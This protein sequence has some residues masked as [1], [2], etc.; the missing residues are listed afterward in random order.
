MHRFRKG[1]DYQPPS[2][3]HAIPRLRLFQKIDDAISQNCR[4]I[5]ISGPAGSG[6]STL[7]STYLKNRTL[8][9]LWCTLS[10]HDEEISEFFNTFSLTA[11][12]NGLKSKLP[13]FGSEY[14]RNPIT[15]AEILLKDV[16][17]RLPDK[18]VWVFDDFQHLSQSKH[19]A[20]LTS[21]LT[22][23]LPEKVVLVVLSRSL[24]SPELSEKRIDGSLCEITWDDLRIDHAELVELARKLGK[25]DS[26]LDEGKKDRLLSATEG[27]ATGIVLSLMGSGAISSV[28]VL[29]EASI[30]HSDDRRKMYEYFTE[31]VLSTIETEQRRFLYASSLLPSM[32]VADCSR[33]TGNADARKILV[34][35]ENM[36]VFVKRHGNLFH[37]FTYHP[38]FREFLLD[39]LGDIFDASK[40]SELERRAVKILFDNGNT[41]S[42]VDILIQHQNWQQLAQVINKNAES[43]VKAGRHEI[44]VRWIE[45][46]PIDIVDENSWL[47]FWYATVLLPHNAF[48]AYDRF[49]QTYPGFKASADGKGMYMCWAG[50]TEAL[51]L[52]H[53]EMNLGKFWMA[54][55]KELRREHPRYPNLELR[56]KVNMLAMNVLMVSDPSSTELVRWFGMAEKA[57]RFVPQRDLRCFLS[58]PLGWMYMSSGLHAPL[59]RLASQIEVLANSEKTMLMARLQAQTCLILS[60]LQTGNREKCFKFTKGALEL[61]EESGIALATQHI[62]D[63]ACY[64]YLSW[65]DIESAEKQIVRF[66]NLIDPRQRI[67]LGIDYWH[68]AWLSLA[69]GEYQI[70][71][72]HFEDM[73]NVLENCTPFFETIPLAG[74]VQ[75]HI[76]LCQFTD[77]WSLLDE[78]RKMAGSF[79]YKKW[80]LAHSDALEAY[81]HVKKG[82]E[83]EALIAMKRWL[84]VARDC[85]LYCFINTDFRMISLLSNVALELSIEPDFV[86]RHIKA[87][88]YQPPSGIPTSTLWPRH[89]KIT[90]FGKLSII[91]GGLPV[92]KGKNARPI[93]LLKLVAIQGSIAQTRVVD[94]LW[95]D[96]DGDSGARSFHT[97]LHRLRKILN[98]NDL[99][100]VSGG[101]LS[102]NTELVSTDIQRIESLLKQA[103]A[104]ENEC[105]EV[106]RIAIVN[107]FNRIKSTY[108]GELLGLEDAPGWIEEPRRR[109]KLAV[110]KQCQK[111]ATRLISLGQAST[112]TGIC[113]FA[114][115]CDGYNESTHR[116]LLECYIEQEQLSTAA[117]HYQHIMECWTRDL[118]A[119][120]PPLLEKRFGDLL[121][122]HISHY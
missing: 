45:S 85:N 11:K 1:A 25:P 107:V 53:D 90:M 20:E 14:K 71:H 111:I 60:M 8:N 48:E 102:L 84:A 116:L 23:L 75:T 54:E 101:N 103:T 33:L 55:L 109:F 29:E 66:T 100:S 67:S 24:S 105:D 99:L 38:L 12:S 35:L 92:E 73:R 83:Q 93:E 69:K 18:N 57:Y 30:F 61:A 3:R 110:V 74:L 64:V 31:N 65:N 79:Q 80:M 7:A 28:E 82:N 9:Y 112:A 62:V 121:K 47:S 120:P 2:I 117:A 39:G 94:I 6:K 22:S 119:V 52:R 95:P 19:S 36:H 16:A 98:N 122:P 108:S 44:V 76:E 106:Y 46:I 113:E 10:P 32:T 43:L 42:A 81:W 4:C 51:F 63:H 118:G 34:N 27:W 72:A 68:H 13:A 104:M 50:A 114:I 89:L 40:K 91:A 96:A 77:A 56:V 97:T 115:T 15:F 70:A 58:Q 87:F 59:Q 26:V 37:T 86:I 78:F 21:R 49:H 17:N 41:E 88:G 5:W